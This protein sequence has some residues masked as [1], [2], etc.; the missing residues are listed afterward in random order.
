[1]KV[2]KV[3]KEADILGLLWESGKIISTCYYNRT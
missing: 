1:M 3:I 2:L